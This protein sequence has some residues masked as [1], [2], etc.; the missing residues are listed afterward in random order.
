MILLWAKGKIF[1]FF[2]LIVNIG[3]SLIVSVVGM[4]TEKNDKYY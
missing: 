2:E 4:Y 3:K 1:K